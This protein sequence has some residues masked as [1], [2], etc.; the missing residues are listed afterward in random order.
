MK[1]RE[2]VRSFAGASLEPECRTIKNGNW[3]QPENMFPGAPTV[4]VSEVVG[5]RYPNELPS[6]KAAF[7]LGKHVNCI[8]G[9]FLSGE[10]CDPD[11]GV[12]GGQIP[13][14]LQALSQPWKV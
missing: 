14:S 1:H 9:G 2:S 12:P 8:R 11:A 13:G 7:Q 10:A 3:R 6:W 4:E 5:R